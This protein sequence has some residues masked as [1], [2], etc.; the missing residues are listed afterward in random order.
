[1]SDQRS[2]MCA[3]D[4]PPW[5]NAISVTAAAGTRRAGFC[6][7][8]VSLEE[9]KRHIR[10]GDVLDW[11]GQWFKGYF[12]V[13][14]YMRD[15]VAYDGVTR[16]LVATLMR[17]TC[18]TDGIHAEKLAASLFVRCRVR[19]QRRPRVSRA[20][21]SAEAGNAPRAAPRQPEGAASSPV[22][23]PRS[24]LAAQRVLDA[25]DRVLHLPLDLI[26]L[27]FALVMTDSMM[28]IS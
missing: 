3:N 11:L 22:Y 23:R 24:S 15:R 5:R 4:Y 10:R 12:D 20:A 21:V 7:T 27:A 2:Q 19:C 9:V 8:R 28:T 1:M 25:A 16:G 26:G 13:G 18:L 6:Y 17:V 14:P